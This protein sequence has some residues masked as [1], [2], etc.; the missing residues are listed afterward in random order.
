MSWLTD[1]RNRYNSITVQRA[2]TQRA[3]SHRPDLAGRVHILS[4]R[5][6]DIQAPSMADYSDYASVHE[7]HVWFYRGLKV[8]GDNFAPLVTRVVRGEEGEPVDNHPLTL[9]FDEVNDQYGQNELKSQWLTSMVF[10]GE[11]FMEIVSGERN[12]APMGFW[13]RR[14]DRISVIPDA[15]RPAYPLVIGYRWSDNENSDMDW[16]AD[17]MVMWK[18]H[19]PLNPWRGLSMIGAARHSLTIDIF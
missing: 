1:V 6:D 12:R 10:S 8:L 7:Q 11:S 3:I 9:L 14:P 5:G 2:M 19:N 15:T 13:S 16:E 4:A 17:E 18:F